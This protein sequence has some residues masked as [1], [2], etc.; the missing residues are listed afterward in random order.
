MTAQDHNMDEL[1]E[2]VSAGRLDKL[3]PGQVAALEAHVNATPTAAET[4]ADIVPLLDPELG[5][6]APAPSDD[7]WNELWA[8]IDSAVSP[9]EAAE[10]PADRQVNLRRVLRF[11]QPLAAA[12]ACVLAIVAW[13][14]STSPA[15]EI[16]VSGDV[17]V[18]EIEVF[19]DDSAFVA[20]DE[21]GTAI[22]WVFE[23]NDEN[24]GT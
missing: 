23:E 12:A 13:Q 24:E 14:L 18:H 6:A 16:E 10:K 5:T 2:L 8:R 19:G 22:V 15:A 3:S 21:K 11:W 1:L 17:V 7:R 9:P 20:Y 4:L